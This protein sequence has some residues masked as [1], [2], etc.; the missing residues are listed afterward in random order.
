MA[1]FSG[2][3]PE[4]V[5]EQY[6]HTEWFRR[7]PFEE[8]VER[9]ATTRTRGF[10]LDQGNRRNGL[11]QVAVPIF[12]QSGYL[13]LVLTAADF[14]YAMTEEK[15]GEVARAM[16]AFSDRMSSELVRLRLE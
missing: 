16:L 3:T 5:E 10:A 13:A 11:T 15:I 4:F 14:S 6:E 7:P 8:Y 1:A 12:S 2:A 9:I